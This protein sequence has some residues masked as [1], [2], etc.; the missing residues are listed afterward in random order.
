[1][2]LL[3]PTSAFVHFQV[4]QTAIAIEFWC[5][6]AAISKIVKKE[7]AILAALNSG[8]KANH[9]RIGVLKA[10][11]MD[12]IVL[13]WFIRCIKKKAIINGIVIMTG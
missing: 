10:P 13:Q 8:S 6:Q 11:R 3:S 1:M 5:Q 4:S 7:D 2:S 9:K 12:E